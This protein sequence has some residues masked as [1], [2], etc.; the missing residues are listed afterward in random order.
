MMT[1]NGR[2]GFRMTRADRVPIVTQTALLL[3]LLSG[4]CGGAEPIDIGSRR[5]LFVDDHLV[6]RISGRARLRLHRPVETDDVFVHDTAWE[7]SRSMY[8]TVFRDGDRYRL[9]YRGS[10]IDL[11]AGKY[12]IPYNV[13]CYAESRDG[14]HWKRPELGL[15]EFG[16]SKKNNI[17][18]SGEICHAFVPFKDTN[19]DCPAEHRYKAIVAIYKP[20]RG[21]HVYSSADGIRW[22]PM[23]DKPVITTGYFDS[24]NL[25]FWDTVRGKYVGFHRALRG[26]P[27]MLKPPSHEASTKDVMTATSSNFLKWSEPDWLEYSPE[28]W[29]RFSTRT[30]R[31]SPF[32]QLYTNQVQPYHRAPHIYVGFPTR[33]VA[34]RSKLTGLNRRLSES[35]EYFGVDY[36]DGGFMTS[37]DGRRFKFWDEAFIRPGRP[38]RGRW[39]YGDNFQALGLVETKSGETAGRRELSM[40][41]GEGLWRQCRL[42]RYTLR[43]DGFVSVQAP[44][45]GGEIVTR[46]LKFAGNRLELNVSTSAAGSVRVEIQDAEGRPLDGFRLSDCREIFG[47]RLDAVVG[48][49]AGPDVGRLAGR[50][51]RLRFVVRDADLFA[52]RF[53]PGR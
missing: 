26:G 39:V 36:T 33:Y 43:L 24:M 10:Q 31:F 47:D 18:L 9:Y 32:V 34:G 38:V 28:R 50:A 11:S 52:F 1:G 2:T 30:T 5:E 40:Y 27:G 51:V 45:S 15:V 17:I 37:R 35:V 46:P 25:A 19:P 53:V 49:T 14:I 12:A 23:S 29:T 48:W 21:L 8:H 42:R 3:I 4:F 20:I 44:L 13:T 16:G 22:S 7:G 6:E 41:V